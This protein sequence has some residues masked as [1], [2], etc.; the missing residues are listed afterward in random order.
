M[1]EIDVS[2]I[3]NTVKNLCIKANLYLPKDMEQCIKCGAKNEKSS[4]GQS[5]FDDIIRNIDVARNE[6]IPI[7][8]DCGMAVIF[9]EVGQDIHF[10]GGS[11]NEAINRGVS[12]GYTEGKL[13]CS[14]VSDP[15]ER[16]N[17]GDNTPPVV[18]LKYTEGDKV[19]ITV[20]P[21]GFGS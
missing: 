10:V 18:H 17:T 20:A 4:V 8:Q 12:R 9:M 15:L 11:I 16:V 1:R 6:T 14:V 5:V 21:K 2:L 7:C 13:R 19:K 3:E